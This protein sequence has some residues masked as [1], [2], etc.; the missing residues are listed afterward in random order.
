MQNNIESRHELSDRYKLFKNNRADF[1]DGTFD[2]IVSVEVMEHV[3]DISAYLLDIFLLLRPGGLFVFT[4]PCSNRF[5]IENVYSLLTGK[6]DATS[7]SYRRWRWEDPTHLR[8]IR[9]EE[10]RQQLQLARFAR[11]IFRFRSHLFSF[12]CTYLP[13]IKKLRP[14][15]NWLMTLDCTL[16]RRVPN[17]AF[18][19]GAAVK[20]R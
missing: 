12:L 11:T 6:I 1:K 2:C 8:R 10:M 20:S 16:F 18:V 14:A 9:S 19:L 15:R 17:G 3:T 4:T 5:S 7:E 13:P